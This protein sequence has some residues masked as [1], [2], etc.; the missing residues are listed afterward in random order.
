LRALFIG[1]LQISL[2][3]LK[4]PLQPTTKE[5]PSQESDQPNEEEKEEVFHLEKL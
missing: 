5:Q 1:V 4:Y 2:Q 3:T